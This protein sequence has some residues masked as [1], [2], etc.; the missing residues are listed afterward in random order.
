MNTDQFELKEILQKLSAEI[1]EIKTEIQKKEACPEIRRKWIPK[2]EV[3][4]FLGFGDTQMS[5]ITKSLHFTTTTIGKRKFYLADS[6]YKILEEHIDTIT[7]LKT[8]KGGNYH[9]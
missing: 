1:N 5:T 2:R 8:K 3:M 6:L 7:V 4:K 9:V